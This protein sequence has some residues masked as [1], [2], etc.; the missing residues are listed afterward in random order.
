MYMLL[1]EIRNTLL[2]YE[3]K[4]I[5]ALNEYIELIEKCKNKTIDEGIYCESHHILPKSMF[6]DY[7][8][9][10]W[11]LVKLEYDDHIEA[12]R[13]LCLMYNNSQMKR[14][15]S[16]M[17]KFSYDDKVKYLTE[18]AFTGENNPSKRKEVREKI[19]KNKTGKAR[20]DM[21][22]KKYFG[23]S[24]EKA[25]EG[26]KKMA[27]KLKNTLVVKDENG[28]MFRVPTDHPDY[29]SG[30]LIPHNKGNG[31]NLS[32]ERMREVMCKI[33]ENRNKKYDAIARYTFIELAEYLINAHNT[34]KNIFSEKYLF[35]RNYKMLIN[36]TNHSV[37]ELY[38]YI[39]QRLSKV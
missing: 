25:K 20:P 8:T 13:L 3:I 22:N 12:H 38:E 35:A 15:Y 7:K 18:G 30:K 27:E 36:K 39:V 32:P 1:T 33:N 2:K 9:E 24:E 26:N 31:K 29:L 4:N 16:F 5:D 28:I 10:M 23:A 17:R 11:N 21:F 14:A 37:N 19:S 6:S 34:G